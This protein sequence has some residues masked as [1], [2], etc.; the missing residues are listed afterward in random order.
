MLLLLLLDGCAGNILEGGCSQRAQSLRRFRR[1]EE[2]CRIYGS[3]YG[4]LCVVVVEVGGG[5]RA[6]I[7]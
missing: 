3:G 1:G 7:V 2:K 5:S 6:R 4:I